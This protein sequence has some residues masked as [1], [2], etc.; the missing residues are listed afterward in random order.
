[1]SGR[2]GQSVVEAHA[3]G[4]AARMRYAGGFWVPPDQRVREG[5]AP[6]VAAVQLEAEMSR[7][8]FA[9]GQ[10]VIVRWF[11]GEKWHGVVVRCSQ[12]PCLGGSVSVVVVRRACGAL[13]RVE[14]S[15]VKSAK[16]GAT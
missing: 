16:G 10:R 1:M 9:P 4:A 5:I 15:R 8:R 11:F 3:Q 12:T 13:V 7:Q 2:V 6:H 14:A